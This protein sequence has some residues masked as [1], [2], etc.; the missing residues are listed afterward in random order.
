ME[1]MNSCLD[2]LTQDS[3]T[4]ALA[5]LIAAGNT[6]AVNSNLKELLDLKPSDVTEEK[7]AYDLIEEKVFEIVKESIAS[8]QVDKKKKELAAEFAKVSGKKVEEEREK[9]DASA[10][11][12]D[13]RDAPKTEEKVEAA[14][15][16]DAKDAA[17][18]GA[19][20]DQ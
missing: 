9:E 19:S 16:P 12:E 11:K 15:D 18:S 3:L 6:P 8:D 17:E 4:E 20:P 1:Q 10:A 5:K 7:S 2:G 13:E 14:K